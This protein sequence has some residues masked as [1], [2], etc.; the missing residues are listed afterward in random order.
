MMFTCM[1]KYH[2]FA[3]LSFAVASALMK[4]AAQEQPTKKWQSIQFDSSAKATRE[5][6]ALEADPY[7]TL[8]GAAVVL[9]PQ[10]HSKISSQH[11]LQHSEK[12]KASPKRQ[13][14]TRSKRLR[15]PCIQLDCEGAFPGS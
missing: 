15:S 11:S 5:H 10:L 2:C 13:D 8:S 3:A 6:A 4:T 7:G 14:H 1:T 12:G 9:R